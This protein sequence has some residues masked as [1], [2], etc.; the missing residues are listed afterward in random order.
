MTEVMFFRMN[1]VQFRIM[2][3]FL[4]NFYFFHSLVSILLQFFPAS[5]S[6]GM[7]GQI[8]LKTEH[9]IEHILDNNTAMNHTLDIPIDA[10]N[11]LFFV[12]QKFTL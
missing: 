6:D 10:G 5:F 7:A 12:C 4:F 8:G 1:L 11:C 9:P 3:L 2:N